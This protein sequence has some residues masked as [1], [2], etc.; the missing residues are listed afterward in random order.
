MLLLISS[1]DYITLKKTMCRFSFGTV[2]QQNEYTICTFQKKM[3]SKT[4]ENAKYCYRQ[5]I[6]LHF[7]IFLYNL[8]YI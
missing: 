8:L 2:M 7:I 1:H 6:R 3:K 4:W 5:Q